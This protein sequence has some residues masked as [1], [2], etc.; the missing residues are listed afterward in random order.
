MGRLLEKV[1]LPLLEPKFLDRLGRD[2]EELGA[3]NVIA[4]IDKAR[5]KRPTCTHIEKWD[6]PREVARKLAFSFVSNIV[7]TVLGF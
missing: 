4:L 3:T 7:N 1:R 2:A 5:E 6:Q